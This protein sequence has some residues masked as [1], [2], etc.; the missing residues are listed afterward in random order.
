MMIILQYYSFYCVFDQINAAL[1][2]LTT[3]KNIKKKNVMFPNIPR[4]SCGYISD[5]KAKEKRWF[6]S[7]ISLLILRK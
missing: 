5:V 6:Y 4:L 1:V 3:F 7:K 2:R